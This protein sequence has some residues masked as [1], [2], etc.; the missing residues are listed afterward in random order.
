MEELRVPEENRAIAIKSTQLEN[1]TFA[2]GILDFCAGEASAPLGSLMASQMQ[3]HMQC[4]SPYDGFQTTGMLDLQR[5]SLWRTKAQHQN[6]LSPSVQ[7][8]T[9]QTSY[10]TSTPPLQL[11]RP[12][13]L[14]SSATHAQAADIDWRSYQTVPASTSNAFLSELATLIGSVALATE[15]A[16]QKDAWLL[17]LANLLLQGVEH[18]AA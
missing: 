1:S 5:S 4:T 13:T 7:P 2:T 14:C 6:S 11:A 17:Q 8:I 18:P 9:T 12:L 3:P 15:T 10:S 16:V